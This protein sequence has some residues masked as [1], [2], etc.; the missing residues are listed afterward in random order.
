MAAIQVRE[1]TTADEVLA[2]ARAVVERKRQRDAEARRRFAPKPV[3]V[4]I[5]EPEPDPVPVPV[6]VAVPPVVECLANSITFT[7]EPPPPKY[8]PMHKIIAVVCERYGIR[9]IDLRSSRRPRSIVRP[10]QIAYH[11]GRMLTPLSLPLIGKMC[12]GKDHTTVLY[13]DR[14][15]AALRATDADLDRELNDIAAILGGT[16]GL[17]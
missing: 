17:D 5:V 1:L 11:L 16:H 7:P 8:P 10:R 9:P 14:K 6:I 13:G 4:E 12:G 15:I 2:N 3:I